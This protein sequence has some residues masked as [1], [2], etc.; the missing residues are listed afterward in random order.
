MK[1]EIE[2]IPNLHLVASSGGGPTLYRSGQPT[3]QGFG[4]I[5]EHFRSVLNL[6]AFHEDP[7]LIGVINY[8]VPC[9]APFMTRA[10]LVRSMAIINDA[11]NWPVL[12]HCQHGSD[13]TGAVIAAYRISV[14]GWHYRRAIREMVLGGFGF[15][16]LYL[17]PLV[18]LLLDW[19][20]HRG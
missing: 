8:Q 5:S 17:L 2:G 18:R 13:R 16:K 3:T 12:V 9:E 11:K 15:H 19:S 7:P 20:Y 6:R 10:H 1:I 14:Q 4:F